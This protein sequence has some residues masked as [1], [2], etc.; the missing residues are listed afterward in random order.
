MENRFNCLV[1]PMTLG[2]V[3]AQDTRIKDPMRKMIHLFFGSIKFD[4]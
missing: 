1:S 3:S 2:W 4:G